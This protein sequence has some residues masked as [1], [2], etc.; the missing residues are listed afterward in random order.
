MVLTYYQ[1]GEY[2]QIIT[3][4]QFLL[5]ITSHPDMHLTSKTD[6]STCVYTSF[7]SL[8]LFQFLHS[9]LYYL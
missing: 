9:L 4:R 8:I 5:Y 6:R 2:L 7:H 3:L 1:I